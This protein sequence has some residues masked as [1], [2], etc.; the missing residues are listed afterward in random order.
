ML[1]P[2][3]AGLAD[4]GSNLVAIHNGYRFTYTPGPGEFGS[5][6]TY[7]VVAEPLEYGV[8]GKRSY[9]TDQLAV[10]HQTDANRPASAGDPDIGSALPGV[11]RDAERH[12][13]AQADPSHHAVVFE[14]DR[15]RVLLLTLSSGDKTPMLDYGT[16]VAFSLNDQ[17]ERLIA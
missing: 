15:A 17:K 1:A 13:A 5:I 4:G 12:D 2:W 8:S 14:N 16:V 7:T 10:I 9:Y 11:P 6:P 3:L